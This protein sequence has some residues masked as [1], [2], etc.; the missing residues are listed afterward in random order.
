MAKESFI[1]KLKAER[2]QNS[3]RNG[4]VPSN[5]PASEREQASKKNGN[6]PSNVPTCQDVYDPLIMLRKH[7]ETPSLSDVKPSPNSRNLNQ[8]VKKENTSVITKNF[9]LQEK[10]TTK[11]FLDDES[12]DDN[13]SFTPKT[14]VG[15]SNNNVKPGS[16]MSKLENFSG[17]WNDLDSKPVLVERRSDTVLTETVS[18][19]QLKEKSRGETFPLKPDPKEDP[20]KKEMDNKKRIQSLHDRNKALQAQHI[21]IKSALSQPDNRMNRKIVF[22][23]DDDEETPPPKE[24]VKARP[25]VKKSNLQLFEDETEEID[26]V[27]Q[28]KPR[29][30]L[31][32]KT[33]REVISLELQLVSIIHVCLF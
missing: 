18:D 8:S 5:V 32:G 21:Q 31:D 15:K 24:E 2:E 16:L 23:E 9:K 30:H 26:G 22:N 4:K 25:K 20:A 3:K 19:N 28:F 7:K 29:P 33:G 27:D 10:N 6:I 14:E 12:H 11:K 17:M 1:S 13:S